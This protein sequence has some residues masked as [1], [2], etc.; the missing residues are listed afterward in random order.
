MSGL[1]VRRAPVAPESSAPPRIQ[2]LVVGRGGAGVRIF[3][4]EAAM[5]AVWNA[6][7]TGHRV[8]ERGGALAGRYGVHPDIGRFVFVTSALPADHAPS[9]RVHIEIRP[10]DWMGIYGRLG[11]LS[12]AR[13]LG[14]YH[15][16]PDFDL[17]LSRTDRETQRRLFDQDWQVALVVDPCRHRF[18]F[19]QGGEARRA[20]WVAIAAPP[21]CLETNI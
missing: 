5:T 2:R 10:Q 21:Q 7:A 14:W 8:V 16:H 11:R 9:S 6:V 15:S 18:R 12:G 3:V 13:L 17:R 20:R 19:Y 1:T 4:A